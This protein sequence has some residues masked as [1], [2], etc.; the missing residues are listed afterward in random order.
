MITTGS[1][2][3]AQRVCL[4]GSIGEN[5]GACRRASLVLAASAETAGNGGGGQHRRNRRAVMASTI[6]KSGVCGSTYPGG[7]GG[8]GVYQTIIN[9]M[10][11]HEVYIEPFLGG[12]AV[13]KMKRPAEL[14]I[15]LDLDEAAIARA[16]NLVGRGDC[17]SGLAEGGVLGPDFQF[18]VGD[19][20]EFLRAHRFQGGELVYCDPPYLF[21][22]RSSPRKLYAFEMDEERHRS[23]LSVIRHLPCA[24]MISGYYS[25]MYA[26][27][28]KGWNSIQFTA[29]TRGGKAATEWL[30]FNFHPPVM[31]HDYRYIGRGFRERERI[32]RKKQ[33]WVQRLQRMPALE[34]QALL[35]A[36][37]ESSR[38]AGC[39]DGTRSGSEAA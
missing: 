13:M 8:S 15:G 31:L 20:I 11:P 34:R 16:A 5:G 2:T 18:Q 37:S 6:V 24:V 39:G 27:A 36:I 33:R 30:W 23:L 28:L 10:P 21:S 17:G 14:N 1:A 12:G 26:A 32:K 22:T 19:G 7:K 9:L 29:M 25:R 3:K 38:I 4:P 35:S